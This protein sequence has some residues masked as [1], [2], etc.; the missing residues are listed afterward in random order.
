MHP[1]HSG[2]IGHARLVVAALVTTT[3][4]V[5]AGAPSGLA[6][7]DTSVSTDPTG[8]HVVLVRRDTWVEVGPPR[9][10]GGS[11]SPTGGCRRRWRLAPTPH[12]LSPTRHGDYLPM[13]L[14]PAPSPEHR[15]YHVWC[16]ATYLSTVWLRPSQFTGGPAIDPRSI[17]ERLARDLPYPAAM[18]AISPERRGLTGL[19]SWFWVEGYTAEPLREAVEGFGLRIE[20]EAMPA[21]V[22]WDFGD[23]TAPSA[24]TLGRAA[25]TRSDVVHVFE[26]GSRAI[27]FTVRATVRLD[28][29]WRQN[30]GPWQP[31]NPVGRTAT[32]TY[33]VAE[34]RAVL[35]PR[36]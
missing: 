8:A 32:R 9:G 17:A 33:P 10:G 12:F 4:T 26:R 29:R 7:T 22:T 14:P 20:V 11:G 3:T 1:R 34:S 25:P 16:D 24:G 28:V 35:V 18:I 15:P 30:G 19:E 13:P 2:L 27:P 6:A 36:D 23:G 31:L 21:M 5:L